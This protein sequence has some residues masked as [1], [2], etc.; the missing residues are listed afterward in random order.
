MAN[1]NF[2]RK[3]FEGI[4][5]DQEVHLQDKIR[6]TRSIW[7]KISDS[8]AENPNILNGILLG[9][10]VAIIVFPFLMDFLMFWIGVVGMFLLSYGKKNELPFSYP[11]SSGKKIRTMGGENDGKRVFINDQGKEVAG[12]YFFGNDIEYG[13]KELW[14]SDDQVRRH[15]LLFG[16]TGAGKTEALLSLCYNAL[17]TCSGFIFSDGKGTFE[18]YFKVFAT[19]RSL[20]MEDD[21]LLISFLTGDEDVHFATT[22]KYSNTLNPF[23]DA[24]ADAS[25]NL[26]VSLMA[27]GSGDGMWKDRASAL[28][29]AIMGLLVYRRD[30]Q[31]RLISVG[32]IRE[33]L[34]LNNIYK[35]WEDGKNTSDPSA[36]GYLSS[37]VLEALRGYLVSLPGFEESK[38][39]DKQPET[40]HEQHGYLFMQFS[41]LLGSLA[42]MYGYIFNTQLSEVNFWDVVTNRRILVVLLPALAKSQNELSMLGKIIIACIKQMTASGLGRFSEG[43]IANV[44]RTN[45]TNAKTAFIAILDEFGYYSV[46]GTSV[47]PAQA[48]G[49]GF[50][51]VFAGQDFP[52]FAKNSKEE[53]ESIKANCTIQIC[54]KLQDENETF[55]IFAKQAGQGEVAVLTGKNYNQD[56]KLRDNDNISYEKR[57]RITFKD[58]N[59]QQAGEA[60][61]FFSGKMVRGRF[62]YI[63]IDLKDDLKIIVNDFIKI[64]P[65]EIEEVQE[66]NK[67]FEDIK[68]RI[69]N[70][71]YIDSIIEDADDEN[72]EQVINEL[73]NLFNTYKKEHGNSATLASC[74][75]LA[76]VLYQKKQII[77]AEKVKRN[78]LTENSYQTS[79]IK[80]ENMFKNNQEVYESDK[81]NI[82][83]TAIKPFGLNEKTETKRM[84]QRQMAVETNATAIKNSVIN[85]VES[86]NQLASYPK[87][88][89]EI[90]R[91]RDISDLI[92]SVNMDLNKAK[93]MNDVDE[94]V[95]I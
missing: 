42:D 39:F 52:A 24:S 3:R 48:R 57:D 13:N 8:F 25:V 72:Q 83:K 41:K 2:Q 56:S 26:L 94:E 19:C 79:L 49:L 90:K 4:S 32:T 5:V 86:L 59:S 17:L 21:L 30:Y 64:A 43:K 67:G 35:A 11:Q 58:L 91:P 51:M 28:M 69:S 44:L 38:P 31:K 54:M 73:S 18:L 23:A 50:F 34:I 45:P 60:H 65:P 27:E 12:S 82:N 76:H 84:T 70:V 61:F 87:E 75:T 80:S 95:P 7:K 63:K 89:P 81:N 1:T 37:H 47:I 53:A 20:G 29:E 74:A 16:T 93:H 92:D 88:S 66:V 6:D 46:P 77:D 33:A 40:I 78:I 71:Q 15:L 62:L 55:Q 14:F 9:M 22:L 85:T 10:F 36:P 68:S